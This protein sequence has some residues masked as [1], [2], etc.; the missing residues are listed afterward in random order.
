MIFKIILPVLE[1][2]KTCMLINWLKKPIE[3]PKNI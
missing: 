1:T 3:I 2:V